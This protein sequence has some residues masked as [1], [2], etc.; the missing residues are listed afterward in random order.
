MLF[1]ALIKRGGAK[2]PVGMQESSS[3]RVCPSLRELLSELLSRF[4]FRLLLSIFLN[5]PLVPN[6]LY[7]LFATR[8]KLKFVFWTLC[9]FLYI[10]FFYLMSKCS[11]NVFLG[12]QVLRRSIALQTSSLLSLVL[13]LISCFTINYSC[14]M[15]PLLFSSWELKSHSVLTRLTQLFL[16]Y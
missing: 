2:F 8:T 13:Q 14:L 15:V 7:S 5:V 4:N 16:S 12:L 11:L 9:T 1:G 3:Q 6:S 10:L